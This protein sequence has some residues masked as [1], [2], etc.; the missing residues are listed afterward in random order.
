MKIEN[1]ISTTNREQT[2]TWFRA[3]LF[4]MI[5]LEPALLLVE[6]TCRAAVMPCNTIE[7]C[8]CMVSN[9]VPG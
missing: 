4:S 8:P 5:E 2:Q 1:D 7:L 3:T 6:T 9:G